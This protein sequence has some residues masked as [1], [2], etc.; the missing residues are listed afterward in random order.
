M[1]TYWRKRARKAIKTLYVKLLLLK[2]EF[3]EFCRRWFFERSTLTDSS[4]T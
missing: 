1:M 2:D 3:L 4:F